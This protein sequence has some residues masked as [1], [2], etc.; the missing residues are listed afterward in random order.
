M[1]TSQSDSRLAV[2][3]AMFVLMLAGCG[4]DDAS[5]AAPTGDLIVQQGPLS[6]PPTLV[7][8]SLD[9]VESSFLVPMIRHAFP[10]THRGPLQKGVPMWD[11][12]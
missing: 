8:V 2:G 1:K 6:G 5:P 11:S 12:T 7:S 9:T 10:A 3:L 4:V